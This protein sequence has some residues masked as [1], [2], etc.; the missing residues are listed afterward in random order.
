LPARRCKGNGVSWSSWQL[1]L[2]TFIG[3]ARRST[4]LARCTGSR[5]ASS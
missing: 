5:R 4:A 2:A 3:K 1:A